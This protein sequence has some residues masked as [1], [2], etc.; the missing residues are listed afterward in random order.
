MFPYYAMGFLQLALIAN[1]KCSTYLS[2]NID[3]NQFKIYLFFLRTKSLFLC[4]DPTH[5]PPK[6]KKKK[7]KKID[8]V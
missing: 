2:Q 6:K 1:A 8:T 7:K 4:P 5:P 3:R